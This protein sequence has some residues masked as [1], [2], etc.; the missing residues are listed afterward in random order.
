MEYKYQIKYYYTTGDSYN[1]YDTEDTLELEYNNID[2]A[3][4]NLIRIKEHYEQYKDLDR[5]SDKTEEEV[6]NYNKYKDWFV[7]K[8]LLIA[9]EKDKEPHYWAI[10]ENQKE[11][12]L[13]EGY[14]TKYKINRDVAKHQLILYTDDNKPYQLYAP[15]CGYFE[16][17]NSA[18]IIHK[19]GV[20]NELK[21][22]F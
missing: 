17:L 2:I 7:N 8:P 16:I 5:W 21:I 14:E 15:W 19:K 18:E 3:K 1:T 20:D 6:F 22:Y 12:C 9:Y 11:R 10:D 4:A 13:R